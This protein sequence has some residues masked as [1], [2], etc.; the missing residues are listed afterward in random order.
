VEKGGGNYFFN[1]TNLKCR[2]WYN[3]YEKRL[4][5]LKVKIEEKKKR[6]GKVTRKFYLCLSKLI[7]KF[8]SIIFLLYLRDFSLILHTLGFR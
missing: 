2:R 7:F 3:T 5:K 4:E 6:G 8:Y 1:E